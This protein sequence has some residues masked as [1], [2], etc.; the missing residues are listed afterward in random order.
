MLGLAL[1]L[2][3]LKL[4]RPWPDE[5][6]VM[7]IRLWTWL[8]VTMGKKLSP[9]ALATMTSVSWRMPTLD[10]CWRGKTLLEM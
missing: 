6:F 7:A 9:I 3:I 8:V 4:T 5:S 10:A 1:G 2:Q